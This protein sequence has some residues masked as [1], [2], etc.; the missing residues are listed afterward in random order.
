MKVRTKL[1]N[2]PSGQ[3]R[4]NLCVSISIERIS[5]HLNAKDFHKEF[6]I[7]SGKKFLYGKRVIAEEKYNFQKGQLII[8]MENYYLNGNSWTH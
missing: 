5:F 8:N 4:T 3:V 1:Q 2:R 7:L 6:P